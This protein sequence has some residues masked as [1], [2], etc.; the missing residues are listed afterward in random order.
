MASN[1]ENLETASMTRFFLKDAVDTEPLT[2]TSCQDDT[3]LAVFLIRVGVAKVVLTFAHCESADRKVKSGEVVK[4]DLEA[5]PTPP[6]EAV[7]MPSVIGL[8]C[9]EISEGCQR[10]TRGHLKRVASFLRHGFQ[11][12]ALLQFHLE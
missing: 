5:A 12:R 7:V 11:A 9:L 10:S 3:L 2:K 4:S 1:L 8:R 6:P